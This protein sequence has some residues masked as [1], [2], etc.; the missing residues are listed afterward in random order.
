MH[1]SFLSYWTFASSNPTSNQSLLNQMLWPQTFARLW[2]R[3]WDDAD[4]VIIVT[5][6][7]EHSRNSAECHTFN[8]CSKAQQ[9]MFLPFTQHG[10]L[11]AIVQGIIH[12]YDRPKRESNPILPFVCLYW[13]LKPCPRRCNI[14][15][16][17]NPALSRY[18]LFVL[19]V[20][21]ATLQCVLISE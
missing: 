14:M 15:Q 1:A 2:H 11:E 20:P 6:C 7:L 13:T 9:S 18:L 5:L 19:G 12:N 3:Q 16:F 4:E 8:I 10:C 21:Q 17:A